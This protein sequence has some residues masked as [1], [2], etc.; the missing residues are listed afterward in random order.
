[1]KNKNV[2]VV[3]AAVVVVAA[4]LAAV[5]FAGNGT[6]TKSGTSNDSA[7]S[8]MG[9]MDMSNDQSNSTSGA[10]SDAVATDQVEIENYAFS[11]QVIKVKVG[12]KVTWT[13]KDSVRHDVMADNASSDAP[14]GPLLAMGESYSFMFSKAGTYTYH[15]SP[16]PYMKATVIVEE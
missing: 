7:M 16:H 3:V 14:S 10:A 15:C 6:D 1:M 12:T 4:I 13:N 5:A 9:N 8:D 2:I 11:P